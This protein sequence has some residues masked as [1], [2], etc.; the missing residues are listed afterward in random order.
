ML[1]IYRD[2]IKKTYILFENVEKKTIFINGINK[3]LTIK[4]QRQLN[5]S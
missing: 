4:S 2:I 1:A 3:Q 5:N